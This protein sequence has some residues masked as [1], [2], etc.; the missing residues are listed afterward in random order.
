MSYFDGLGHVTKAEVDG[1][2]IMALAGSVLPTV[3][4]TGC[5]VLSAFQA[6]I[7]LLLVKVRDIEPTDHLYLR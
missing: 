1:H 5:S 4:R 6:R 2:V 7:M 3:L